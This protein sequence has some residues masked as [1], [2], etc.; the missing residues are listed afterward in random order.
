MTAPPRTP[1]PRQHGEVEQQFL[2]AFERK[3]GDDQVAAFRA[4]YSYLG[5]EQVAALL[6][7]HL[8]L[9]TVA[10]GRFADDEI[11]AGRAFRIGME[12]LVVR[13]DIA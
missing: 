8:E 10:I 3:G 11:E 13:T 1:F 6:D 2:G 5:F 7:C 9:A 12:G 4:G